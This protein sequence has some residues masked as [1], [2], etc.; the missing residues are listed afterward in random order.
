MA[1]EVESQAVQGQTPGLT[2]D[3]SRSSAVEEQDFAGSAIDPEANDGSVFFEVAN[4]VGSELSTLSPYD[5]AGGMRQLGGQFKEKGRKNL[6]DGTQALRAL[7]WQHG[8]AGLRES[9]EA[10][11]LLKVPA[12]AVQ[13]FLAAILFGL[14]YAIFYTAKFG[15]AAVEKINEKIV[16][17]LSERTAPLIA[18]GR[19]KLLSLASGSSAEP[20]VVVEQEETP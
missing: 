9:A 4:Q 6:A 13:L 16:K 1:S 15:P 8:W 18:Q 7:D 12:G 2:T 11:E 20:P 19:E 14:F 17:P 3:T 5:V 10:T